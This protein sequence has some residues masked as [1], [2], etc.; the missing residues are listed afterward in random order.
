RAEKAKENRPV[1]PYRQVSSSP[2]R[3]HPGARS[4]RRSYA[5]ATYRRPTVAGDLLCWF[6]KYRD[7]YI[8]CP[9]ESTATAIAAKAGRAAVCALRH[10]RTVCAPARTTSLFQASTPTT[11]FATT[12][13]PVPSLT[14]SY[15]IKTA[16]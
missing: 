13:A 15:A 8:A 7:F 3:H 9:N 10:S 5:L 4:A 11:S 2:A 1:R 16:G 14:S 12:A 6:A